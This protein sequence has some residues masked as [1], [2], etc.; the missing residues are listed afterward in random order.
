MMATLEQIQTKISKLEEQANALR[1]KESEKVISTIKKLMDAHNL[2]AADL[3]GAIPGPTKGSSAATKSTDSKGGLPPKYRDPKS[4]LTWSGRARPPA[5]I[6]NVKDRSKFLIA[7]D[8]SSAKT[9]AALPEQKVDGRKGRKLD[10][11]PK[12]RNL[13]TG[14]TWTGHGRAPAWIAN[15]KD[16]SKFLIESQ[17][18]A[19]KP[20]ATKAAVQAKAPTK[21]KAAPVKVKTVAKTKSKAVAP[22]PQKAVSA[23]KATV[24]TKPTAVKKTAGAKD[25]V[26]TKAISGKKVS[27]AKKAS[28]A[29]TAKA[30][31]AS[32]KKKQVAKPAA[33]VQLDT[34]PVSTSDVLATATQQVEEAAIA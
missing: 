18:E 24:A 9:E 12:Y 29:K 20:S 21:V 28:P 4:G 26:A 23:K 7:D 10:L 16:R 27:V 22:V 17:S 5:W 25:A 8:E 15:V 34:A 31:P 2:T 1:L 3:S 32:A 33:R 30:A 11:S 13:K 6:A 19:A 14:A